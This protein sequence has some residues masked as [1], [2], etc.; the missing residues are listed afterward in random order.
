MENMTTA[1]RIECTN[2]QA[3]KQWSTNKLRPQVHAMP[4]VHTSTFL[5]TS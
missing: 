2:Q 4:Y 5:I 1:H 3:G